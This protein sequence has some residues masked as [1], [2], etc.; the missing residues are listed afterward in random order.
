MTEKE[1]IEKIKQLIDSKEISNFKRLFKKIILNDA[2]TYNVL[3]IFKE[4][5]YDNKEYQKFIFEEIKETQKK[6]ERSENLNVGENTDIYHLYFAQRY[7]IEKYD[8]KET[9]ESLFFDNEFNIEIDTSKIGFLYCLFLT[10]M[11][12]RINRKNSLCKFYENYEIKKDKLLTNVT[13]FKISYLL[14]VFLS[15]N[16][17]IDWFD[18]FDEKNANEKY[19]VYL[20]NIINLK[21]KGQHYHSFKESILF[22]ELVLRNK[23]N[24]IGSNVN[25][26]KRREKEENIKYMENINEW[27]SED[28]GMNQ[29]EIKEINEDLKEDYD[30]NNTNFTENTLLLNDL[31]N[32]SKKEKILLQEQSEGLKF[33]L[34]SDKGQGLNLRN[35]IFHGL[36]NKESLRMDSLFKE[37]DI[38][39]LLTLILITQIINIISKEKD[40]K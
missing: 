36:K 13:R 15:D 35:Q 11:K 4:K 1:T 24:E 26:Y 2:I 28:L 29:K 8:L 30:F 37:E 12:F 25:E 7:M 16:Y 40:E 33:L 21:S 32:K 10:S 9:T 38:Y 14:S 23:L 39:K 17:D 19:I 6:L 31:I 27:L 34:L 20:K 22:L 5:N 3:N 18:E